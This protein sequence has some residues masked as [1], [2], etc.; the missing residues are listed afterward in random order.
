MTVKEYLLNKMS[1]G[2]L[3]MALLDP[4]KQPAE[5][6]GEIAR[7]MKDAGSDAVMIG[8][9]TGVTRENLS[10]T[11]K[12]IKEKSGLPTIYF[13]SNPKALNTDIDSLFFMSLMNSNELNWVI[14]AQ[15]WA[16]PYIRKMGIETM[17]MGYIVVEPGMKV[18][19]VGKAEL[20]GHDD[21][22]K[23]VSYAMACEMF[24][25][26]FAYLEA[27]SGADRPISPEMIA[28][29]KQAIDIPL[30][31]GGGIRTPEAAEAARK[32]G[33]DVIVTGTFIEQCHDDDRLRAVVKAA[34][35]L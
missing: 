27:G 21:I 30:F 6:A 20:V 1:E 17:S 5:E 29:V 25:M 16:A 11:A 18:G 26:D 4:D 8:G 12:A 7:H 28:A 10:E 3:H 32:A 22:E 2:T 34:K 31:V 35:G 15:V 19:Q 9:S 24:G 13:P 33:A 23:A 14:R